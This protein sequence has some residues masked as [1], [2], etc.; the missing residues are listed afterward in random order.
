MDNDEPYRWVTC[1]FHGRKFNFVKSMK[2]LIDEET[3]KYNDYWFNN[4]NIIN[5]RDYG[6]Y[7][8]RCRLIDYFDCL[9][10]NYVIDD[11]DSYIMKDSNGNLIRYCGEDEDE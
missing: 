8:L 9:D 11:V 3:D 4:E 6:I 1:K 5:D 2:K 7:I 10:V